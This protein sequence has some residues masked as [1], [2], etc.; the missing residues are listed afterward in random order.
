[1]TMQFR[2]RHSANTSHIKTATLYTLAFAIVAAAVTSV[3]NLFLPVGSLWLNLTAVALISAVAI[4]PLQLTLSQRNAALREAREELE[5]VLRRDPPADTLPPKELT[6]SVRQ[7]IDRR[8]VSAVEDPDGVMLVLRVDNFDEVGG[9]YGAQWADTLLQS[10]IQIVYSS[11]RYGDLVARLAADELGIYLPGA[12]TE[13]VS[14]ICERIRSRIRETTFAAGCQIVVSVRL[15]GTRF[16]D[17]SDFQAIR[18]AA[19]RA[20]LAEEETGSSLFRER[21]S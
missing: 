8:H 14:D 13:N 12:T 4:F 17:Q 2:F 20:A 15:G 16:G 21:F 5:R 11:V 19:K 3:L 1:M 18:E 9:R 7:A 6:N 10:I